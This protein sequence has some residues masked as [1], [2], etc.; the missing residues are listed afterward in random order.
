MM[1]PFWHLLQ[2]T[3]VAHQGQIRMTTFRIVPRHDLGQFWPCHCRNPTNLTKKKGG[4]AVELNI[5]CMVLFNF[6]KVKKYY[7]KNCFVKFFMKSRLTL[8]HALWWSSLMVITTDGDHHWWWWLWW[9]SVQM[10]PVFI[11]AS[12][13]MQRSGLGGKISR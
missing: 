8:N 5:L 13:T 12:R 9:S 1:Q 11:P 7:K 3:Q 4:R 10:L 6:L 2:C